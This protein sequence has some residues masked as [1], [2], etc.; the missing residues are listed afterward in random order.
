MIYLGII[1]FI[2]LI[3]HF[4]NFYFVKIGL[5]KGKADNFYAIAHGLFKLPLYILIYIIAFV[6]LS[7]H[8]IHAFQSA[9]QTMGL[10]HRKYTPVIKILGLFYSILIPAGF[11]TIPLIIFFSK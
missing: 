1:I 8:L 3:I 5:V 4:F 7:F 11:I 10:N 2:F 9:F 6:I